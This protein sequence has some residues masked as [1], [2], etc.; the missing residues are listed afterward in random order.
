[1]LILATNRDTLGVVEQ[2]FTRAGLLLQQV[3]EVLRE[4][5]APDR[6]TVDSRFRPPER[7]LH[8]VQAS[9]CLNYLRRPRRAWRAPLRTSPKPRRE[10]QVRPNHAEE[11]QRSRRPVPPSQLDTVRTNNDPRR[12]AGVEGTVD[13]Q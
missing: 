6:K 7:P 11:R 8:H 12:E 2:S 13:I 3:D 4:G 10:L 9:R 5:A 1:M